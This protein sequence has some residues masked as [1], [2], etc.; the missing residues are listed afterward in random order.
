M[1]PRRLGAYSPAWLDELRTGGEVVWIGAGALAR[2]RQ[3]GALL[4]RGRAPRRAAAGEREAR[5]A[6][7]ASSTTRS[8]SGSAPAPCFWL[9]LVTELELDDEELHAA[10]WD[11]VWAGEVTNDAFAP[12]RARRLERGPARPQRAQPPL[13]LPPQRRARPVQG[14]WSLTAPLFEAA[15]AAGPA[16]ARPGRA[17]ARAL[18]DRHPRD[19]ARR[20]R[21]RRLR[22]PLRRALEPR[23]ARHRA[24][25]LL[26]R[27]PRRSPVRA[28]GRG[29]AAALAAEPRRA[30]TW[31]SRRPIRPTPTAPPCRGRSAPRVGRPRPRA[32]A[33][34]CCCATASRSLY[35][36]RGGQ[37]HPAPGRAR[38][39]GARRGDRASSPTP[40]ASGGSPSSAIERIDGEPVIGSGLEETLIAAGFSR[41]PRRLV[42]AA[43]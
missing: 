2:T 39:G 36:E 5:A 38:G 35:V 12:L 11:L 34:T 7:R 29:R 43:G 40:P 13:R 10:L 15:P 26:R 3:G 41:Q 22:L 19:R 42:A 23:D 17:D 6:P 4:P 9:D 18:R 27:G 28:R 14:R 20:G 32:R 21:A 37:G 30:S 8:A 1:L 31:S 25:R 33:P 16:A 24:P